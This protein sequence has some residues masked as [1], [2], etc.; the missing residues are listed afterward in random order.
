MMWPA[1]CA[2]LML[3]CSLTTLVT[4]R[5][6]TEREQAW[7][8]TWMRVQAQGLGHGAMMWALARMDDTHHL[9]AQCRPVPPT[10]HTA[11]FSE[12]AMRPDAKVSCCRLYTSDAADEQ[13]GRELRGARYHTKN[14][15]N[16]ATKRSN[17]VQYSDTLIGK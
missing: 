14:N 16:E 4:H 3:A 8:P 2:L 11:R 5:M 1:L 10:A 17:I 12:L 9:D 13:R 7:R 6:V 15:I